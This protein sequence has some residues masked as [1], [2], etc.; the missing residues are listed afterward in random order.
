MVVQELGPEAQ[1]QIWADLADGL[2][3]SKNHG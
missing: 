3:A 2:Y 1:T